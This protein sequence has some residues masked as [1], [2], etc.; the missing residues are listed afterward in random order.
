MYRAQSNPC[1]AQFTIRTD[2]GWENSSTILS[3]HG[4]DG[5]RDTAWLWNLPKVILEVCGRVENWI[6]V[7][8]TPAQCLNPKTS[9]PSSLLI[10]MCFGHALVPHYCTSIGITPHISMTMQFSWWWNL[11]V[12]MARKKAGKTPV[13]SQ[14]R[15]PHGIHQAGT[16]T[17]Y[18]HLLYW[19]AGR[20]I[21]PIIPSLHMGMSSAT[22]TQWWT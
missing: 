19:W 2:K 1:S 20:W 4:T 9:P 8:W 12:K 11:Q 16:G 22:Y 10:Q 15:T 13:C 17:C 14:G 18:L 21:W 3:S 5:N 6:Q 7:F